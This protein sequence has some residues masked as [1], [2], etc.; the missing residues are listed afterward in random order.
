M[1]RFDAEQALALIERYG[2]TCGQF[3]PTMFVRMLKLPKATRESYDLSSLRSVVHAAAPCPVDVKQQM[4]E[5]W[6]PIIYEYY[7]STEGAGATFVE[8][9][10]WLAHPGT[11]GKPMAG[12]VHVLDDDGN[13]LP[14]GESGTLWFEG[15]LGFEYRNDPAKTADAVNALGYKTVGDMGYV[16]EEGYIYLTDR[17]AHMII[18]GG[19]NIYPQETENVLVAHP[20]VF[21]VAVIGV[22]DD[23]LGEQVKAVVQP[24]DWSDAGPELEA[25]LIEYCRTQ[26]AH[27]KCPRTIDFERELPRLDTGKLYK[28]PFRAAVLAGVVVRRTRL[29]PGLERFD[30]LPEHQHVE[31]VEQ[32]SVSLGD[33]WAGLLCAERGRSRR[34]AASHHRSFERADRVDEG[35]RLELPGDTQRGAQVELRE[36]DEV[37]AWHPQ[38]LVDVLDRFDRL[39]QQATRDLGTD[40]PGVIEERRLVPR[41]GDERPPATKPRRRVRQVRHA[42]LRV[43]SGTHQR[44]KDSLGARVERRLCLR[45]L[46]ARHPYE[47]RA[48]RARGCRD[49]RVHG[50]QPDRPVLAIDEHEIGARGGDGLRHHRRRNQRDDAAE[51]ARSIATAA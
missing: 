4:M 48:V 39:Q 43:L 47:R 42:P 15:P 21:D 18:S 51:Q 37:D 1:E 16:D 26:I 12:A 22:P 31:P 32:N 3:V 10:E 45:L 41:V 17:K 35:G 14:V 36:H 40:A 49:H 27:Y 30:A 50:L 24:A 25:E 9:E 5:W 33:Q 46:D 13:E 19:V 6:G 44:K 38:D 20:K 2:V 8:P 7:S 34:Y 23:D 29:R 28:G 11:V